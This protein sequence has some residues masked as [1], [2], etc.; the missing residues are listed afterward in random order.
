MSEMVFYFAH[1]QNV[2][3]A[4]DSLMSL[5]MY[6][7]CMYQVWYNSSY[8]IGTKSSYFAEHLQSDEHCV[9]NRRFK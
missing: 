7:T 6:G 9:V 2:V 8:D 3:Y 1:I 4:I 5:S